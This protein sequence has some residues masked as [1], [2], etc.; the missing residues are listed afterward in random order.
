MYKH[1]L[2]FTRDT[3]LAYLKRLELVFSCLDIPDKSY[4]MGRPP[5]PI[6]A[7]I[8]ALVFKNLRG[9]INLADL[10]REL[11]CYPALSQVCGFKSF[12]CKE[13]FSHFLKYTHSELF[14][15]IKENLIK[16][17]LRLGEIKAEYLSAD[18][19]P[20]KSPVKENNPKVC[21]KNRFDKTKILKSDKEARIGV[22]AVHSGD[23]R[24]QFFWGYRNHMVNDAVSEL[25]LAEI[26]RPANV[27]DATMLISQLEYL[28]KTFQIAP[29]ALAADSAFDSHA[30]IEYIAK[31]LKAKPVIARNPRRGANP[32]IKISRKGAPICLAGFE[33]AS[34]GRCYEKD[35]NRIRHKF[36]CPIKRSENFA[37]KVGWFCPWNHPNFY[38]NK[39]GCTTNLRIDVDTSI[40]GSIDY[41]SQTFR[42]IYALR[43]ASER[44]FSRLSTFSMQR[45]S[46]KGLNAT[47]NMCSLAHIAILAVALA[48]ARHDPERKI[49]FIKSFFYV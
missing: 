45:S 41:G 20:V 47:S 46:I 22:Y 42:K 19:C 16:E 34:R 40:R 31:E 49:R 4:H 23:K 3:S 9:L 6:S 27:N 28:K 24:I 32:D 39:F 8:N 2:I 43:T 18:S 29:K 7:M 48:A 35:R 1:N 26:T 37:R 12:P 14:L 21:I 17:L 33:M 36:V 25:P 15:H 11:E 30:I 10:S 44:I 5:Y 38:S 13:R